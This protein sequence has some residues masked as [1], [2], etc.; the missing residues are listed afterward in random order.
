MPPINTVQIPG[1]R[2]L[3]LAD[4][5]GITRQ[6]CADPATGDLVL[7]LDDL[8]PH[9]CS[10]IKIDAEGFEPYVI[11]GAQALIC[12]TRP[13]LHIEVNLPALRSQGFQGAEFLNLVQSWG[14]QI[15]VRQPERVGSA[16][17]L[18]LVWR[19][20]RPKYN[21]KGFPIEPTSK[22]EVK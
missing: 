19:K 21:G 11:K 20:T 16:T 4:D 3:C 8:N 9:A 15:N 12:R 7:A 22:A 6:V 1:T 18:W 10:F 14:Y 13:I 17:L 2:H 5:L